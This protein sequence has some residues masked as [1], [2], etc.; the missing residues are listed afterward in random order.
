MDKYKL[1]EVKI[2]GRWWCVQQF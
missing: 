2:I 1:T